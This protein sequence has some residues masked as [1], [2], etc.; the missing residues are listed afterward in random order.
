[1]QD[2]TNQGHEGGKANLI[3]KKNVPEQSKVES[4]D[5]RNSE[6]AMNSNAILQ[7]TEKSISISSFSQLGTE[8]NDHIH[9]SGFLTTF[10]SNANQHTGQVGNIDERGTND[11]LCA[12]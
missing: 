9:S 1:L 8:V 12:S 10:N 5:P 2:V 6:R 11:P 7:P 3:G 4:R